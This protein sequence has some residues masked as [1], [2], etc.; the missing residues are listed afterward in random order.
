MLTCRRIYS[1]PVRVGHS[2]QAKGKRRALDYST[3]PNGSR[4]DS[5]AATGLTYSTY[6]LQVDLGS[7]DM[8]SLVQDRS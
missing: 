3:S 4:I 7:S 1:V 8:V 5:F 2:T 6:Q